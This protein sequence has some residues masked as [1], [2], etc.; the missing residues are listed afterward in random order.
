MHLHGTSDTNTM[1]GPLIGET[2]FGSSTDDAS[3]FEAGDEVSLWYLDGVPVSS[4]VRVVK[5]TGD[6]GTRQI[7]E[8][9]SGFSV[10]PD[11]TMVLRLARSSSY[12]N[13]SRYSFTARPF[14]FFADANGQLVEPGPVTVDGDPFGGGSGII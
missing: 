10:I 13:T 3:H 7:V 9:V 5:L 6:N 2:D 4:E 14:V 1:V 11:D 12:A 8:L